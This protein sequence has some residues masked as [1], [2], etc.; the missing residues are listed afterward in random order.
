[1]TLREDEPFDVEPGQ[2]DEPPACLAVLGPDEAWLDDLIH[3]TGIP[4]TKAFAF[5][6]QLARR[7]GSLLESELRLARGEYAA[8]GVVSGQAPFLSAAT[9]LF[10]TCDPARW[11]PVTDMEITVAAASRTHTNHT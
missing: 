7:V 4:D 11:Q 1:M 2:P 6:T 3:E 8:H 10:E 9:R 5:D